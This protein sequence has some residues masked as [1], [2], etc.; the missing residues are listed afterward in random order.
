MN[1]YMAEQN[2]VMVFGVAKDADDFRDVI[3]KDAEA[4]RIAPTFGYLHFNIKEINVPGYD[5]VI[6]KQKGA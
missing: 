2:G 6:R 3:V 1:L 4:E 5:I